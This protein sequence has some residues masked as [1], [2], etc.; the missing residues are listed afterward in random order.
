MMLQNF[1]SD[2]SAAVNVFPS[3]SHVAKFSCNHGVGGSCRQCGLKRLG[4]RLAEAVMD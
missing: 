1:A 3:L 2:R 4:H